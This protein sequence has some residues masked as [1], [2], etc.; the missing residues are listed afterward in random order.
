M[1]GSHQPTETVAIAETLKRVAAA[2]READ[3]EFALAGSTAAWAHGGPPPLHD[4]DLAVAEEDAERGLEALAASGMR[5]E[6]PPEGWLLKAWNEDVLV[7]L[8]WELSG[9]PSPPGLFERCEEVRVMA[10]NMQVLRIDD[11]LTSKLLALD[12]HNLDLGSHLH[13]S[14]ALRE[15]IDWAQVRS[16]TAHSPYAVGFMAMLEAL[17]VLPGSEAAGAGAGADPTRPVVRVVPDG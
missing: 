1:G 15:K 5:T 11:V 17:A 13:I 4:L 6:R 7:D 2:L 16:R 12:E 8:I 3:V 9:L 10:V 14:R